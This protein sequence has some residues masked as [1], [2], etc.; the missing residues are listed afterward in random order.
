ML[1]RGFLSAL[2]APAVLAAKSIPGKE[3]SDEFLYKGLKITWSGFLPSQYSVELVGYWLALRPDGYGLYATTGGFGQ[4]YT[5]YMTMDLR[6][7]HNFPRVTAQ[8]SNLDKQQCK[9]RARNNIIKMCNN[10][11][12]F[13]GS[14]KWSAEEIE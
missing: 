12:D 14:D 1:R 2:V 8:S 11:E 4:F 3:D 7:S 10:P 5:P 13:E 9:M 6:V